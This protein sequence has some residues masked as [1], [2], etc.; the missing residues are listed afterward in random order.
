MPSLH[1]LEAGMELV[2]GLMSWSKVIFG[3]FCARVDIHDLARPCS[4]ALRCQDLFSWTHFNP[5]GFEGSFQRA[6]SFIEGCVELGI[7]GAKQQIPQEVSGCSLS[8]NV[9][10]W[11]TMPT[12]L[13][14]CFFHQVAPVDTCSTHESDGLTNP[15]NCSAATFF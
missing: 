3:P 9:M 13:K 7:T 5:Q 2:E 1:V 15:K 4:V 12:Y 14:S 8:R 11:Y 6:A 10:L